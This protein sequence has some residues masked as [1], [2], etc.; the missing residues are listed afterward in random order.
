VC[1]FAL[2]V[3]SGY[4]VVAEPVRG[5]GAA[6]GTRFGVTIIEGDPNPVAVVTVV[7]VKVAVS[8]VENQLIVDIVGT[9][10]VLLTISDITTHFCAV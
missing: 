8:T 4:E 9:A 5:C 3:L 1:G 6:L 2:L 10:K 7:V